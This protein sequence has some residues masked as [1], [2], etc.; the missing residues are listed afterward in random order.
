MT[1]VRFLGVV[2]AVLVLVLAAR[3]YDRRHISRLSLLIVAALALGTVVLA[4]RAL[5]VRPPVRLVQRRA[6]QR[7]ARAVR[8]DPR[9]HRAVLPRGAG[10]V[11][12]RYERARDPPA[13]RGARPRAVRLGPRRRAPGRPPARRGPPRVQRGGQRRAGRA[14]DPAAPRR[15]AGR[16][17]RGQ[18]RQHRP[19]RRGGPRSGRVRHRAA[20][21]TAA[22]GWRF[23][24][25]T[26]SRCSSAPRSSSRWT[27]TASTWRASSR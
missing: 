17:G 13:G 27:P 5:A 23:G 22:A 1:T 19:H 11:R 16:P 2:A 20:R 12:E 25:A 9:R 24:S 14:V 10:A 7:A 18:R 15:P 6:R 26:R 21:S 3:A 4:I 8:R